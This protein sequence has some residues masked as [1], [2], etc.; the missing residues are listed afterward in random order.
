MAV[1]FRWGF[2]TEAEGIS[3]SLRVELDLRPI[4]RLDCVRLCDYLGIPTLPLDQLNKA[5]ASVEHIAQ[6]KAPNSGFSA[7]TVGVGTKRLIV[8][9]PRH[10]PGRRANSLAHEISHIV[11][12]HPFTP[13]LGMGGCRKW[14][15]DLEAEADWLAGALL[16]PREGALEWMQDSGSLEDGAEHF[17]VSRALFRWRVNQTGVMRQI[18]ASSRFYR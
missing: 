18:E 10:P 17:G 3:M 7:L 11:L 1:K 5:G 12:E 13:A 16:V 9:N 4:D 14:N 6:L 8:Y 2:K 15:E